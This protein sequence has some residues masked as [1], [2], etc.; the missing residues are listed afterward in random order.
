MKRLEKEYDILSQSYDIEKDDSDAKKW[1]IALNGPE[2]SPY[3]GGTYLLSIKIPG[4]YPFEPPDIKFETKIYHP[5]IN[6]KGEI[7]V[8]ILKDEW[9]PCYLV[10]DGIK[11]IIEI[12]INPNL[13]DPLVAEIANLYNRNRDEYIKKAVEYTLKYAT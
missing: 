8:S 9:K 13:E 12:L 5:N 3:F 11:K 2:G 10:N 6:H 4:N 1:Q 7:C